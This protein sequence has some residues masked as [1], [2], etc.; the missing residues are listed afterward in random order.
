MPNSKKQAGS[1]SQLA[2]VLDALRH[3]LGEDLV[4]VV[5]FGSRSR[6]EAGPES[7]WDLLVLARSLPERTMQR[8]FFLKRMLPEVWRGR[9]ALL[10][11]TPNEFE[12]RLP[13]LYLDIALDGIVLHDTEG[14]MAK[15]LHQLRDLLEQRGLRRERVGREMAWRWKQFPGFD[16]SLGWEAE[17]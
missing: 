10:A 3:G 13:A 14:Y 8:H 16:W 15:R 5:L 9:I 17:P 12:A 11:K 4:S 1:L 6:E 2:N 7:D